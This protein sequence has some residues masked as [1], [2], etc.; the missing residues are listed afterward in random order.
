[1]ANFKLK[2]LNSSSTKSNERQKP[3]VVGERFVSDQRTSIRE[4]VLRAA[5]NISGATSIRKCGTPFAWVVKTTALELL[6][7]KVKDLID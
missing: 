7:V 6:R 5:G 4:N 2:Y 1:M 3:T